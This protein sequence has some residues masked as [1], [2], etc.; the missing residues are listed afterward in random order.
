MFNKYAPARRMQE[1]HLHYTGWISFLIIGEDSETPSPRC[2]T[3]I[4]V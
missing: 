3:S 1:I 2:F 4:Y